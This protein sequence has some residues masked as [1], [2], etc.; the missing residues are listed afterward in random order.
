VERT[1]PD[2]ISR[3]FKHIFRLG[4]LLPGVIIAQ[5]TYS[6][7]AVVDLLAGGSALWRSPDTDHWV[8]STAGLTGTTGTFDGHK[9]DPDASAFLVSKST[10]G[11]DI[12]VS[13][14]VTFEVG[15]YL[16]VYIDFGQ[17]TQSGMWLATGH[18]L[19]ADA[20]DNEVERAYIK[21]VDDSFW[22]VR[23]NAELNIK[24]G[25]ALLLRFE[26][27]GDDY[28]VW[29]DDRLIATYHKPGGYPAG[30]LQLRLVNAKVRISQLEV[31]S[32]WMK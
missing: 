14:A 11:G 27:K 13:M 19:A 17:D 26:R 30:P 21:T 25:E 15:R 4:I 23:A 31:R 16:G 8:F 3:L 22:I 24:T 6:A 28:S 7:E 9:T 5:T 10:F 18:A 29:D 1:V 12:S 20:A 2:R 32:D